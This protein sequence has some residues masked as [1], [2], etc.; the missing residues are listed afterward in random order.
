MKYNPQIPIL[1]TSADSAFAMPCAV[2]LRSVADNLT[3]TPYAHAIVVDVGLTASDRHGIR[4]S[5][6]GTPLNVEFLVLEPELLDGLKVDL[7]V[8]KATYARLHAIDLLT[9]RCERAIYVDSDFVVLR[10]IGELWELP[11][12]GN[13]IAAVQ[14]SLAG[15]AGADMGLM[16]REYWKIPDEC[17][18]FNAGLMVIDV[19]R[20]I[21]ERIGLRALDLIVQHPE[22]IRWWDQDAL[23][24]LT[25]GKFLQIDP[26][27]NVQPHAFMRPIADKSTWTLETI[28]RCIS[29]PRAIHFAGGRKPWAGNGIVWGGDYFM[30]YLYRTAWRNRVPNAPWL[31]PKFGLGVQIRRLAKRIGARRKELRK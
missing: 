7:H 8:S 27:W 10:D 1:I 28:S 6:R 20:W 18:C 19:N 24:I 12:Q 25:A 15:L 22:K 29:Q 17:P 2:M 21:T 16:H 5:L 30:R 31:K 9:G 13:A 26:V 11:L 3:W 23:N 4:K 14:D